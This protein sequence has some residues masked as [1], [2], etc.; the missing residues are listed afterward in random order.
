MKK[1]NAERVLGVLLRKNA[2]YKFKELMALTR[3]SLK[4]M[5]E[6]IAELRK[7][8]RNLVFAK[9]DRTYYLSDTPTWYNNITDLSQEMP[10]KGSFGLITDTHLCSDAERLDLV[11]DAYDIFAKRGI[12][13][14]FHVGDLTDGQDVYKG[15]NMHVKVFGGMAQAAYFIAKYPRKKGIT[16]Y[17]ISGNHDLSTY[18]KTGMD[19]ASLITS[20]FHYHG[21]DIKGREDIVYLGQYSHKIILPQEVTMQLLHPRGNNSYAKSYKQQKR[22]EAMDRN[23]QPDIQVSGHFH[24]FNYTWINHCHMLALPGLQDETEFFVRLGL[25]RGMGFVIVHYEIKNGQLV[26]FTPELHMYA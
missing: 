7:S 20:G 23:L 1:T 26:S 16:T 13:K 9:F 3:L 11:R 4:D 21:K 15:H 12:S 6:T 17:A 25:P 8:Q 19:Q 24:D 22:R 2:R 14:V 5:R 10:S 18:L